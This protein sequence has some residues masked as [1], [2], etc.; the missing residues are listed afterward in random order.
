[1]RIQQWIEEY[2]PVITLTNGADIHVIIG[3]YEEVVL[4]MEKQEAV[5]ADRPYS[6][7]SNEILSRGLKFMQMSTCDRFRTYRKAA[8]SELQMKAALIYDNDQTQYAGNIVLDILKEPES[9]QGHIRR[10]VPAMTL[11]VIYGKTTQTY[12][13][14]PY[15]L[16]LQRMVPIVQGALMPGAYKVDKYPFLKYVPGYTWE[17]DKWANFEH[18]QVHQQCQADQNWTDHTGPHSIAGGLLSKPAM[19]M[20]ED[21]I[22]CFCGSLVGASYDTTQVA[23]STILMASAHFPDIQEIVQGEINSVVGRDTRRSNRIRLVSVGGG[24]YCVLT[25]WNSYCIPA[26]A[27]VSGNHWCVSRDPEMFPDPE[28]FDINRWIDQAGN[29]NDLKAYSF[30]FGR[31]ICPGLN[32]ANRSVI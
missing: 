1:Q 12:L 9:H 15:I 10:H 14:D 30:G 26:N 24:R 32:L 6:I 8:H 20:S 5:L 13:N 19:C 4:L 31:R 29:L 22:S 27:T 7:A 11:R 28:T 25:W 3:R 2:G 16:H 23:I 21:E 18:E 17:L